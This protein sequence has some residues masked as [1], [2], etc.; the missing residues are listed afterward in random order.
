MRCFICT[1]LSV[2]AASTSGFSLC[3]DFGGKHS[4]R[5]AL[6]DF[7]LLQHACI[8]SLHLLLEQELLVGVYLS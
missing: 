1:A 2:H 7:E 5:L 4:A 6:I 3:M 8:A